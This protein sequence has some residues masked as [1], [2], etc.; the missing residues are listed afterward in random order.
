M[1][2]KLFSVGL[3]FQWRLKTAIKKLVNIIKFKQRL[4]CFNKALTVLLLCTFTV[5]AQE[6]ENLDWEGPTAGPKAVNDKHIL[7]ISQDARNGGISAVFRHF[8]TATRYLGWRLEYVNGDNDLS[9]IKSTINEAHLKGNA[10]IVLAGIAIN[11]V[12]EEVRW[13]QENGL[14]LIGWHAKALPGPGNN[15]FTNITTLP[16]EIAQIAFDLMLHDAE[17]HN[18]DEPLGV[19]LFN[20]S[21]F[22]IA[23][24][25]TAKLKELI[26]KCHKCKL[27]EVVDINIGQTFTL[28]PDAV[29]RLNDT[30]AKQWTH[31]IAIND[32]YFDAMNTP[33]KFV[34]RRDIKNIAAGDG[35]FLA[36]SRISGGNSQQIASIAEPSGIQGW[37]LADELNRAFSGYPATKFVAPPLIMTTESVREAGNYDMDANIPYRKKYK[38]IWS[39]N[40]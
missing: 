10:A 36:F 32:V 25:K 37:Q 35:S 30:Y 4:N 33:L 24:A 13:A 2:F 1:N 39:I 6:T 40:R 16:T 31:N 18:S 7:F 15:M 29:L 28:V 9:L 22:D 11:S 21:R 5:F 34:K 23:N 8:Q 38:A 26:N 12:I 19:V 14:I 3:S 20:D 27:L 17:L